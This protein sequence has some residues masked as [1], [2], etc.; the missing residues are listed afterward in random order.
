MKAIPHKSRLRHISH[1]PTGELV[2]ILT[3][4][5]KDSKFGS[6]EL[7]KGLGRELSRGASK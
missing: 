7:S 5:W 3:K 1:N 6:K 2:R 4:E